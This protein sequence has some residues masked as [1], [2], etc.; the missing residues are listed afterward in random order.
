MSGE[1]MPRTVELPAKNS[2]V[3]ARVSPDDGPVRVGSSNEIVAEK[4]PPKV[5]V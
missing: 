3:P 2:S 5:A 1:R 4:P